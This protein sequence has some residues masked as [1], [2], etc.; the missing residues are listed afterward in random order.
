MTTA[1]WRS[2]NLAGVPGPA[3]GVAKVEPFDRIGKIA[4]E[5]PAAELAIG[6]DFKCEFSLHSENSTNLL[7]LESL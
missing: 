1:D 3:A 5:V 7:V 4:H 2:A 6:G